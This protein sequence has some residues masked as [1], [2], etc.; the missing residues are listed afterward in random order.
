[1]QKVGSDHA[2]VPVATPP[3]KQVRVGMVNGELSA[4]TLRLYGRAWA[5]FAAFCVE[6][7]RTALPAN[8]EIVCTFLTQPGHGRVALARYLAAIDHKHRQHG[9]APPGCDPG[10]RA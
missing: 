10:V 3:P 8:S 9:F 7:S 4:E 2:T 1:M 5:R 6:H